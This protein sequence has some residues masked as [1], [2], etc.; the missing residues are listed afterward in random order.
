[1]HCMRDDQHVI[2]ST[3]GISHCTL[4][5]RTLDSYFSCA[6]ARRDSYLK[7]SMGCS[8]TPRP[9]EPQGSCLSVER[10]RRRVSAS[11]IIISN[12]HPVRA[13]SY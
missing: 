2:P 1:M 13:I 10:F 5:I 4:F 8:Y 6:Y 7:W 9:A 3:H 11:S 12:E